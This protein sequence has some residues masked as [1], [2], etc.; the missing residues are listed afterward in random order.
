M[1]TS[2]L[3]KIKTLLHIRLKGSQSQPDFEISEGPDEDG[4][5]WA[6]WYLEKNTCDVRQCELIGHNMRNLLLH[7]V[8]IDEDVVEEVSDLAMLT[9]I[10]VVE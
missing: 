3:T 8:Y 2:T 6:T 1:I 5:Q 10:K 4:I 7:D 9:L